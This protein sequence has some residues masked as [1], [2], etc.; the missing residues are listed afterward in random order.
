MIANIL[1]FLNIRHSCTLFGMSFLT[2]AQQL[3]RLILPSIGSW[4]R[5]KDI[6]QVMYIA[7]LKGGPKIIKKNF[8]MI[9]KMFF[10][11]V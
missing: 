5:R 7:K 6:T 1:W 2:S 3:F 11:M 8:S 4:V 10:E 9:L